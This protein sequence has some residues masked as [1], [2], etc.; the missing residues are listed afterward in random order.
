MDKTDRKKILTTPVDLD[1][2][3]RIHA[4]AKAH[5]RAVRPFCATLLNYIVRQVETGEV[6]VVSEINENTTD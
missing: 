2:H 1:L 3:E 4:L 6:I 5:G